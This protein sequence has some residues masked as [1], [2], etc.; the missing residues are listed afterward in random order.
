[1]AV[2]DIYSTKQF[3]AW[4]SYKAPGYK[5]SQFSSNI[6]ALQVIGE[7]SGGP[8]GNSASQQLVEVYLKD[9]IL[10]IATSAFAGCQ[11]LAKFDTKCAKLVGDYALNS[12]SNLS[13]LEFPESV[14]SIGIQSLSNCKRLEMVTFSYLDSDAE[15][16]T[17]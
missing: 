11:S 10:E 9:N 7:A 4:H 2:I 8:S 5:S 14:E 3:P 15:K 17:S 6:S 1:M 12:C 13:S 16:L